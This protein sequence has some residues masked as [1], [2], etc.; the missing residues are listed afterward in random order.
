MIQL[1]NII[2]RS[3]DTFTESFSLTAVVDT[4]LCVGA[5]G[6]TGSLASKPILKNGQGQLIIPASQV[7][8]RLRHECEKLLRALEW[9]VCKSPRAEA[10]CPQLATFSN[11]EQKRFNNPH[12]QLQQKLGETTYEG[13]D[14]TVQKHCLICQFFGNPA[15]PARLQC[16]DLVCK[17]SADEVETVLRPGVSIN[18]S[19][20]T[21]EDQKLYFLETSPANAQ[22]EFEGAFHLQPAWQSRVDHSTGAD[23]AKPLILAG[24]RRINALGGGKST[25]LGW[26]QWK[27][28]ERLSV[29]I[30]DDSWNWLGNSPS[31][32]NS[33]RKEG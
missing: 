2:D 17:R 12:Y 33:D 23:F 11:S 26:L 4:A 24:L 3:A 22:L 27:I 19:R 20:K 9:P 30:S 14:S 5:G 13:T 16:D 7:K 31:K 8:G 28:D 25:G 32:Q 6:S 18:R 21:A 15:L 10:M 29:D 1:Q